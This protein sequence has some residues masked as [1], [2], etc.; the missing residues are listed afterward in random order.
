MPLL[1]AFGAIVGSALTANALQGARN[2]APAPADPPAGGVHP[3]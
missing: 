2:S 1:I 3:A